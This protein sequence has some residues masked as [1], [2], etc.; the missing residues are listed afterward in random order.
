MPA[1]TIAIATSPGRWSSPH[2]AN[3]GIS[4]APPSSFTMSRRLGP[5]GAGVEPV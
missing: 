3:A 4:A 1:P 2:A 5:E